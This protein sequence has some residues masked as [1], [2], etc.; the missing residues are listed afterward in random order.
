MVS[1]ERSERLAMNIV[2]SRMK[3]AH[4]WLDSLGSKAERDFAPNAEAFVTEPLS[5]IHGRLSILIC[6]MFFAALLGA[7]FGKVDIYAVAPARIQPTGRSK[8]IQPLET[9]R[10]RALHVSNGA[11]V[12]AGALLVELDSVESAADRAVDVARLNALRATIARQRT[13]IAAARSAYQGEIPAI[14]FDPGIETLVQERERNVLWADLS[15]LSAEIRTLDSKIREIQA[16]EHALRGGIAV[17][18]TLLKTLEKRVEMRRTLLEKQLG[19]VA[20]VIDAEQ[21][22]GERASSLASSRGDLLRAAASIRSLHTDKERAVSQFVAENA[23]VSAENQALAD[24]LSQTLVK[25]SARLANTRLTAPIRG[26]VQ[27]SAVTTM[28]QVVMSGQ[29]LMTIVPADAPL[30]AEAYVPNKDIG[31]VKPGQHA[32]LKIDAFP[33]TR[34]GTIT[35]EISRVS[36]DAV[37]LSNVIASGDVSRSPIAR[38]L[39]NDLVFPVTVILN[40]PLVNV[41]GIATRLSPG[42]TARA[43]IRTG[44]RRLLEYFFS[45]LFE[46]VTEV[47]HER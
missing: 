5:P 27:D 14:A 42:M 6:A 2:T 9:G 28:G 20:S 29:L 1:A 25:A 37:S 22:Y 43:E 45:P 30:E 3:W 44:D 15:R 46:A 39:A 32:V 7:W 19:S 33:F 4:A 23:R 24:E 18:E 8:V 13:A 34:H 35:G 10:V 40:V 31:F 38:P 26:T 41:Q 17:Q 12:E 47:A 16:L 11:F 36:R 21:E